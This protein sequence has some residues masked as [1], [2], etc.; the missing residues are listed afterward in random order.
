MSFK[1]P[2]SEIAEVVMGQSPTK[3]NVNTEGMGS[4]LLNGPT[5]FTTRNPIPV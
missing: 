2:F 4:P 1:L 3:E 5:E